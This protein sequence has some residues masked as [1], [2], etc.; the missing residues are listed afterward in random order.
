MFDSWWYHFEKESYS[1][2]TLFF[3]SSRQLK[4]GLKQGDVF[5]NVLTGMVVVS[6]IGLL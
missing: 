1:D 6:V 2:V 4:N 3:C 5:S